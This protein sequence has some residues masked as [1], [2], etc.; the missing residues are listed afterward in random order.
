MERG[1]VGNFRIRIRLQPNKGSGLQATHKVLIAFL[2][3]KKYISYSLEYWQPIE[4]CCLLFT[5][6]LNTNGYG[7]GEG[8]DHRGR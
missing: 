3:E 5:S 1:P 2:G 4:V 6:P 8:Q 7:E